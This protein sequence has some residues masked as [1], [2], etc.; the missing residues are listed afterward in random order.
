LPA[1]LDQPDSIAIVRITGNLYLSCQTHIVVLAPRVLVK[2]ALS[3]LG[4]AVLVAVVK[5][6]KIGFR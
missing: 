2:A 6:E 4:V 3:S 1:V 5:R